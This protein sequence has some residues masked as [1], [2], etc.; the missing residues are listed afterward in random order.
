MDDSLGPLGGCFSYLDSLWCR[1]GNLA[2]YGEGQRCRIGVADDAP[3]QEAVL[4]VTAIS[5]HGV[6]PTPHLCWPAF[7]HHGIR[8]GAISTLRRGSQELNHIGIW[9]FRHPTTHKS[10]GVQYLKIIKTI[11]QGLPCNLDW[12]VPSKAKP[13]SPSGVFYGSDTLHAAQG[14]NVKVRRN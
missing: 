10:K 1:Y 6:M 7:I 13:T 8:T 14:L 5:L 3:A 11:V 12:S 2:G 9:I 4:W